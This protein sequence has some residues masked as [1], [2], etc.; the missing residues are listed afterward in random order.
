MLEKKDI[1]ENI[2][3]HFKLKPGHPTENEFAK[4]LDDLKSAGVDNINEVLLEQVIQQ[5]VHPT[6]LYKYEGLDNSNI[7]N[8][9]M[10]IKK[11]LLD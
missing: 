2:K 5:N 11:L 7:D 3:V 4:I 9:M 10:Q 1:R 6:G 8:L